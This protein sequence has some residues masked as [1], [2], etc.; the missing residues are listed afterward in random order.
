MI[1]LLVC[2]DEE[3]IRSFEVINLER[4]GY[5]VYAVGSGEEAIE[6]FK[7]HPSIAVA[8]L[9]V[10]LPGIDGFETCNRLR[11]MSSAIGIIMLT[12]RTQ[13]NEKVNGFQNGADDYVTKPFGTAE[14]IARVD[15]LCRRIRSALP[16]E[17]IE[18]IVSGDFRLNRR[19]RQLI[20]GDKAVELTQV[21]FT[22]M[23]M[24]F[25]HLHEPL[26]RKQI[27]LNVWGE[28]YFGDEK[29]VDVNIRRM[30]VKMEEDPSTPRHLATVWGYGYQWNG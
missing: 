26:T 22:L 5:A 15:A 6:C 27:L 14:L 30:R 2:E 1:E 9:D 13:E 20:H 11:Q 8:L 17:F 3:S 21:E 10:M 7:E 16:T 18:E 25:E 12:A 24:F 29:I 28:E 19:T 4:A 23:E